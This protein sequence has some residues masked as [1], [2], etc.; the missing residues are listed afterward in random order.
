MTRT[1]L[2]ASAI[3]HTY[4]TGP[5]QITVLHDVSVQVRTG[6]VLLLAGPSGS[7]KT[8][9]LQIMGC[10]LK[11][12]SGEVIVCGKNA[13]EMESEELA[14]LR[15]R[16]FGFVFQAYNL[17]P[18]LTA[19]E[20]VM[21]ALDLLGVEKQI[22]A[23]RARALLTKVGLGEKLESYPSQLSGGQRERVAIARSMAAG[24]PILMA[25]EPTAA[26]DAESGQTA[27]QLF[28]SLARQGHAVVIVTHDPRIFH[29]ADRIIHLEDGR[30]TEHDAESRPIAFGEEFAG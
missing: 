30:M 5:N 17:F 8:T 9:L 26:L 20:N 4:E 10:L 23:E 11:P 18:V 22:A 15:L 12:R 7:G 16:Q 1:V 28:C 14:A 25:D 3:T 27:M 13:T 29:L 21:V 19:T 6:E 2:T 24:P